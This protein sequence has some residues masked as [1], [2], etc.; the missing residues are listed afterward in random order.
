MA[1]RPPANDVVMLLPR[2]A[3]LIVAREPDN[4]HDAC[5]VKV[6]LADFN[7]EGPHRK[8]YEGLVE[9]LELD[10]YGHLKWNMDSLT[11][12]FHLGYVAN[13]TKTG[14]LY[15]SELCEWLDPD[16]WYEAE[17]TFSP[18]GRPMIQLD[19]EAQLVND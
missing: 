16:R 5:A 8:L 13:S 14:G 18:S 12:P 17:L 6:M 3:K 1:F 10:T 11:D 7:P 15:A 9:M 4:P 2:G 19:S